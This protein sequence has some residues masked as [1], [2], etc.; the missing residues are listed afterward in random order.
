MNGSR[1]RAAPGRHSSSW[2]DQSEEELVLRDGDRFFVPC[3]GGPCAS[4]LET[5]PPRLEISERQGVYVL[6]DDG[7]RE[8]WA[9]VFVPRTP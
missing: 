1:D 4:R 7:P 3:E 2:Y 5:Y 6:I 8:H 9:Y